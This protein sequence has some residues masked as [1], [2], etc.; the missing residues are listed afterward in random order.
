MAATRESFAVLIESATGELL[1]VRFL[2]ESID[3]LQELVNVVSHPGADFEDLLLRAPSFP[4]II[5][6]LEEI[7]STLPRTRVLREDLDILGFLDM[8]ILLTLGTELWNG[9]TVLKKRAKNT[10]HKHL[11]QRT[12]SISHRR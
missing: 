12:R 4:G 6:R 1:Q 9:I 8:H 3:V 2:T 10:L 7:L 5:Q 11:G